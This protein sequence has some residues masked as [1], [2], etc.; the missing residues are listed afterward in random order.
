LH[1]SDFDNFNSDRSE[2]SDVLEV[3]RTHM[4]IGNLVSDLPTDHRK[5]GGASCF[6]GPKLS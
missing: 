5:V 1:N 6:V 4:R 3:F 2:Q